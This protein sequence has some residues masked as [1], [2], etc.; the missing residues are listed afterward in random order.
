MRCERPDNSAT[1]CEPPRLSKISSMAL[2][3]RLSVRNSSKRSALTAAAQCNSSPFSSVV[4]NT[5]LMKCSRIIWGPERW[6]GSTGSWKEMTLPSFKR[7]LR[8]CSRN[9]PTGRVPIRLTCH[10]SISPRRKD[11]GPSNTFPII[12][13]SPRSSLRSSKITFSFEATV[14]ASTT[15][16]RN[17]EAWKV[18]RA[19]K[20]APNKSSGLAMRRPCTSR[21]RLVLGTCRPP[22]AMSLRKRKFA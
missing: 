20:D 21:K 7:P 22:I 5:E 3:G 8:F 19:G 9:F 16:Q 2:A 17:E 6:S 15:M 4:K 14:V 12:T 11:A 18:R 1:F 10:F 13:R